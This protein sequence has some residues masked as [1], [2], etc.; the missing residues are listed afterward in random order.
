MQPIYLPWIGYFGLMQPVD[1]FIF[2]SLMSKLQLK[3]PNRIPMMVI[4]QN[5]HQLPISVGT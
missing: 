3:K 5:R 4:D 1:F 2:F